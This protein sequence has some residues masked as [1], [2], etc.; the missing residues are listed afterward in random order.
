MQ[1]I[2]TLISQVLAKDQMIFEDKLIV[3][4]AL[5]LFVGCLLHKTELI[6][7]F[8]AFSSPNLDSC[9]TFV[10]SG[11]LYTPQEKIREEFKVTLRSLAKNLHDITGGIK[12]AP[13][14]FLLRLL[15]T[16]FS[17][18]SDYQCK[19]FFELFCELID[20]YF[21]R[22]SVRGEDMGAAFDP[23]QLLS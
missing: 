10:L 18:I 2:L 11:L 15:S 3:E 9:E 12:E 6:N 23:E 13:L 16:R 5:S 8:Y 17:Q 7:D 21:M 19:Q 20:L 1:K 14:Q 4:N 22:K